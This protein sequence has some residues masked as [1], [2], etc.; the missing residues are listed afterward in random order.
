MDFVLGLESERQPGWSKV[1]Y[2]Q[3]SLNYKLHWILLVIDVNVDRILLYDSLPSYITSRNLVQGL[4]PLCYTLLSLEEFYNLQASKSNLQP[5]PLK[6]SRMDCGKQQGS[7]TLDCGI[8]YLKF[9][10]YLVIGPD[11]ES[12]QQ[13]RILEFRLQYGTK[14][15]ADEFFLQG[16]SMY[17]Y[18][19][20]CLYICILSCTL[21]HYSLIYEQC[22][23]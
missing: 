4:S 9:F 17:I 6:L 14:L 18:K 21:I 5:G 20:C 23:L 13:N 12:L 15:W 2:L 8:F 3:S 11:R 1:D 16:L 22:C 7:T 10:Q 19:Q